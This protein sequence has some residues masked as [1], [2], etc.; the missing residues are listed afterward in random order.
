LSP[1]GLSGLD[2]TGRPDRR[3]ECPSSPT[4]TC[5][6]INE[7]AYPDENLPTI[8]SL[9]ELAEF[10]EKYPDVC[11]RYSKGPADDAGERSVDYESGLDLPGL[12]VNPLRPE[13]WWTRDARDWLARQICHYASLG[14]EPGRRAW[15]IEGETVGYGPDREPL[16]SPWRAVAW[17]ADALRD[18]ARARYNEH[19][20][21]GTDSRSNA[22][23]DRVD[24][25][26]AESFPA[27][28]P[29]SY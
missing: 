4:G 15:L 19:F 22:E 18:E 29:P 8:R 20:D 14:E 5:P 21:A 12:S 28:D 6:P 2:S 26:S 16:L 3:N 13:A 1:D 17:L 7:R 24:E 11:I 23:D 9:D 25:M 10:V 27:S